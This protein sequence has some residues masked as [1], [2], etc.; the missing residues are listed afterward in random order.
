MLGSF[1]GILPGTFVTTVFGNQVSAGLR[2][3]GEIKYWIIACIVVLLVAG[4]WFVKRW[5]FD[6]KPKNRTGKSEK[7]TGTRKASSA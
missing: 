2:N 6:S 7:H 1:I 5:L 3:P 4:S